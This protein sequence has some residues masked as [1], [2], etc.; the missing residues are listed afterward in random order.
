MSAWATL[1]ECRAAQWH[2]LGPCPLVPGPK[3]ACVADRLNISGSLPGD[4]AAD[5][6]EKGVLCLETM[7]FISGQGLETLAT[8][9]TD[10]RQEM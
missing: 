3:K 1:Q 2:R 9:T 5:E 8:R 6:I 4:F 7:K 10:K